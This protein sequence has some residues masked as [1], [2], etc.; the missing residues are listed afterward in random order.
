V[1]RARREARF[2]R[3]TIFGE[4]KQLAVTTDISAGSHALS[5]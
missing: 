4:G 5:A 3:K 1:L 2:A